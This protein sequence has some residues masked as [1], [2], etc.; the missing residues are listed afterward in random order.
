MIRAFT[1]P[2]DYADGPTPEPEEAVY[3]ARLIY[4]AALG[5]PT[6]I[7]A[8]LVRDRYSHLEALRGQRG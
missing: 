8:T 5:R 6:R 2:P 4:V 7:L 1:G 3:V